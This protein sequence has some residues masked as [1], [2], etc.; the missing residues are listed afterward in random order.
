M[1]AF[2]ALTL[3]RSCAA[4]LGLPGNR[5]DLM[6]NKLLA[7]ALSI[8][9]GFLALL[10][11][12]SCGIAGRYLGPSHVQYLAELIGLTDAVGQ[13]QAEAV[14]ILCGL[15]VGVSWAVLV[16]GLLALIIQVHREL[17][18]VRRLVMDSQQFPTP[19]GLQPLTV[20]F[21]AGD[22]DSVGPIRGRDEAATEQKE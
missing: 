14:G 11:I 8:L 10:A 3:N 7:E 17:K 1:S 9:N 19:A 5:A 2:C 22:V 4:R 20:G 16:N 15:L 21:P 6:M 12:V 13:S 18:A